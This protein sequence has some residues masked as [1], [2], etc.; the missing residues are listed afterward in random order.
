MTSVALPVSIIARAGCPST[1]VEIIRLRAKVE[2]EDAGHEPG[3]AHPEEGKDDEG[4]VRDAR[5]W[6]SLES[7]PD[8]AGSM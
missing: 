6:S 5:R 3:E 1:S 7:E 8:P 2:A 4:G